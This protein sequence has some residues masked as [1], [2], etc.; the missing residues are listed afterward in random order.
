MRWLVALAVVLGMAAAQGFLL[1]ESSGR[2]GV[3]DAYLRLTLGYSLPLG[4]FELTPSLWAKLCLHGPCVEGARGGVDLDI[5]L[6]RYTLSFGLDERGAW[7][8]I[9]TIWR[10]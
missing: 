1:T 10:F 7:W 8:R 4:P 5:R 6:E 2:F 3:G 9:Y